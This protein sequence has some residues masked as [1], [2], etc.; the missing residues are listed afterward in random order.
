[1]YYTKIDLDINSL[2]IQKEEL[3]EVEWFSMEELESMVENNI[4]NENQ[5]AFFK[6]CEKF[7][8]EGN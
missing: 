1:M 5:V 7:L 8:S 4:L 3:T 2:K 6:K